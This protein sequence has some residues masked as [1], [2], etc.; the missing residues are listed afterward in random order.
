MERC[1]LYVQYCHINCTVQCDITVE[2]TA[3]CTST[4]QYCLFLLK[5]SLASDREVTV[6]SAA[7]VSCEDNELYF[8]N[9]PHCHR[10]NFPT[11]SFK[12]ES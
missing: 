8:D 1:L 4:A 2:A 12:F 5:Q 10:L 6:Q 7:G 9:L 11:V 3:S